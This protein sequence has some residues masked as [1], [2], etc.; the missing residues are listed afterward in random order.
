MFR[1]T[2]TS[3]VHG[4]YDARHNPQRIVRLPRP[5]PTASRMSER[6]S[7][8]TVVF[9]VL[10]GHLFQGTRQSHFCPRDQ[11][12]G[13]PASAGVANNASDLPA[14]CRQTT[15]RHGENHLPI[16]ALARPDLAVTIA[17]RAE[18]MLCPCLCACRPVNSGQSAIPKPSAPAPRSACW[19]PIQRRQRS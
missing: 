17:R 4:R 13:G 11:Y 2:S 10:D 8:L 19:K 6:V 5:L 16:G 18:R 14:F 7:A 3:A 12:G 9:A 15:A 1:L